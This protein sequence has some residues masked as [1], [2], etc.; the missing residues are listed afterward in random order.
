MLAHLRAMENF[1]LR[2]VDESVKPGVVTPRC[3]L[4]GSGPV[5]TYNCV[6]L[7]SL[8]NA[9]LMLRRRP[10]V[11]LPRLPAGRAHAPTATSTAARAS[12]QGRF[13]G[14]QRRAATGC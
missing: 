3:A 2:T 4:A 12:A 8:N 10:F 5:P 9:I 1:D 11:K 7:T 6:L 14:A 13:I